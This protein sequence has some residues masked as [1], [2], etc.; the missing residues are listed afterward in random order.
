MQLLRAK[1]VEEEW[2]IN[3]FFKLGKE[4]I[5]QQ[6]YS[7]TTIK[8]L[9]EQTEQEEA[10]QRRFSREFLSDMRHEFETETGNNLYIPVKNV[11]DRISYLLDC[12]GITYSRYG[13]GK[14][15]TMCKLSKTTIEDYFD[16]TP[17]NRNGAKV[18]LVRFKNELLEQE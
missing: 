7:K 6:K 15:G 5:E 9:L 4:A 10:L 3:A 18:I 12:Y 17:S 8:K 14:K 16:M 11:L 13:D 1:C 2:L